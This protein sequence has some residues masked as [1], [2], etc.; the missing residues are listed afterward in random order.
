MFVKLKSE[1][2]NPDNKKLL[3]NFISLSMLQAASFILPLLVIPYLIFVLGIEKFG[4]VSLAQALITYFVVFTDYGFNLTATRDISINRKNHKKITSIFSSVFSTKLLLGLISFVFLTIII[5]LFPKLRGEWWLFYFSFTMVIGQLLFPVWFFQGIE[6]MKY[7]TYM[8]VTAKLIFTGLVFV[9][10]KT[11]SDYIYVNVLNGTG[12]IV[13]SILS[14]WLVKKKFNI[15]FSFSNV[16]RIKFQLK[17]GWHVL[18]SSFS[19]NVYVNSNIII[20]GFYANPIIIG[21][22]SV[23][24]KIMFAVRQLLVVFS[25]VIYPHICKLAKS[26]HGELVNFFKKIFLPFTLFVFIC[27][28][29]LFI[30][31]D[32]V[33][34]FIAGSNILFISIL[35]KLFCFAPLIVCLNIPA[36]Q[37]LLA[38][39]LKKSYTVIVTVG[40]LLCL[41]LNVIL[42]YFFQA[43]GTVVAI[44]IT[45]TFITI[46]L[47]L[48]LEI[49]YKQY[50]LLNLNGIL[51]KIRKK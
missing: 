20:L 26:S 41:G 43:M 39:N 44:L 18:L 10:I 6:Q 49:K 21:Y 8:S 51:L 28:L 42:A 45:E 3:S 2:S 4:L 31:S 38:Y 12:S 29:A 1:F 11:P 37:T 33:V 14:I 27:S 47:Y 36:N 22:Y 40:S 32:K 35:V 13:S 25:Q 17:E 24:E 9:L 46:G 7:I 15:K 30:F 5:L 23:A 48:V 19:I 34:L 16:E 50:S